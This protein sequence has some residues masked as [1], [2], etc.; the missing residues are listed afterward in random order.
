MQCVFFS[1]PLD[2]VSYVGRQEKEIDTFQVD[3]DVQPTA[4]WEQ[5]EYN[6]N[7]APIN[8]VSLA[9]SKVD[10]MW[11]IPQRCSRC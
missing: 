6:N 4:Y 7:L 3:R 1:M 9:I 11:R 8:H 10:Y 2:T 5:S